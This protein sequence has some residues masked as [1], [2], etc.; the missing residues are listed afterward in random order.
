MRTKF[1]TYIEAENEQGE[2]R[3]FEIGELKI[4]ELMSY[5]KKFG[6]DLTKNRAYIANGKTTISVADRQAS[7]IKNNGKFLDAGIY[8]FDGFTYS[9]AFCFER[10]K[11]T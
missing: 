11:N 9:P 5:A 1:S 8:E 7:I 2:K 6:A 3:T 4:N 10:V